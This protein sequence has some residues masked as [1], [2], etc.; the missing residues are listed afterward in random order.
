MPQQCLFDVSE[1]FPVP[2]NE[3]AHPEDRCIFGT[4]FG[5]NSYYADFAGIA[6]KYAP[7]AILEIGVRYGYS[8]IAMC[9]GTKAAGTD[10]IY[11]VGC[12]AEYFS[13][14]Q[15]DM[16][17]RNYRSNAVAQE[18]FN[19]FVPGVLAEFHTINT[20]THGLP[21]EVRGSWQGS[22]KQITFTPRLFDIINVDGD[23]S[24]AGASKDL[25]QTWSL[26]NVGGILIIDDTGMEG[27]R[28][29]I[30]VFIRERGSEL[31][32]QWHDNERGF[33]ICRK[34]G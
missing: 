6:R 9:L 34:N 16:K 7:R 1:R 27:V 22:G 26:L 18:N 5:E 33:C 11:Y 25:R 8:G 31:D 3:I 2:M 21:E 30:E 20:Q 12:D 32:H 28:Q 4:H 13:G 10:P 19:R 29:A 17:Y 15:S 14:P 23:H 24:F